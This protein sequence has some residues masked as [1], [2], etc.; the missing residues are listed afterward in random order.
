MSK[1]KTYTGRQV[2]LP[3]VQTFAGV[4]LFAVIAFTIAEKLT[5]F[6]GL[7][8]SEELPTVTAT[9]T[10]CIEYTR[11]NSE[12]QT[13]TSYTYDFEYEVAGT[14]YRHSSSRHAS[15]VEIGTTF[16]LHY[17]PSNPNQ[18]TDYASFGESLLYLI[19]TLVIACILQITAIVL[20]IQ[21]RKAKLA[22]K[23]IA[24]AYNTTIERARKIDFEHVDCGIDEAAL[25]NMLEPIRLK[26]CQLELKCKKISHGNIGLPGPL[27]VITL[28]IWFIQDHRLKRTKEKLEAEQTNFYTSYRQKIAEPL[29]QTFFPD[30]K[31]MPAQG[32][33][34]KEIYD[35][36]IFGNGHSYKA[37]TEDYVEGTY[38]NLFYKQSDLTLH[39]TVNNGMSTTFS[40]RIGIYDIRQSFDGHVVICEKNYT[41]INLTGLEKVQME[42]IAF[43]QIFDVYADQP[44]QAYYILTPHF[45][46]HIMSLNTLGDLC[47]S[48]TKDKIC[49]LRDET[50]GMFEPDLDHPLNISHEIDR[51]YYELKEIQ[52]FIDTLALDKK[53]AP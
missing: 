28:I 14:T 22:A 16:E 19:P 52:L 5:T 24:E 30:Y 6:K 39:Y 46:E 1:K 26:I 32:I 40:G 47:I 43:N 4:L 10:N 48:F 31:Y 44:H 50:S 34:E 49:I 21:E 15:P 42:N 45:M 8:I 27:V 7:S 51:S 18:Y 37:H 20:F 12:N 9:Y 35:L 38:K 23:A 13:I 17:S 2:A 25:Y 41:A 33:P 36:D 53:I 29:L 3:I 11:T